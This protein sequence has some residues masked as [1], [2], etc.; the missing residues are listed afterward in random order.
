MNRNIIIIL[1]LLIL[2][3]SC[4][5]K[6]KTDIVDTQR[7]NNSVSKNDSLTYT[8]ISNKQYFKD[9]LLKDKTGIVETYFSLYQS[10]TCGILANKNSKLKEEFEGIRIVKGIKTN[11]KN[12]TVFVMPNFNYCDDG[13]SYYF[14]D[15]YLPRLQTDSFCCHPENF[16]VYKDI[17]EDGFNEVGIFYSSCLSRYK[18]LRIYSLK[19]NT[20]NEIGIASFDIM[21][22]DPTK[23]KFD[24]LVKKI[25]KNKF[26][27]CNFYEGQT[28]W[29]TI[30]MK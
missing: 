1:T 28:E 4:K 26:Q 17:D 5:F 22:K 18:S 2:I 7:T 27:I 23:V 19:K 11:K 9:S 25:G 16:F 21:T 10:D 24:N 3:V 13:E 20:W 15:K 6:K 14:Y 8:L 30:E 12:D 29:K